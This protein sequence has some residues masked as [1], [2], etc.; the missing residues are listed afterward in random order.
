MRADNRIPWTPT[1]G[2]L[3]ADV[4]KKWDELEQSEHSRELAIHEELKR[5]ERLEQLAEIFQRKAKMRD[6]WL[7]DF[8]QLLLKVTFGY[9]FYTLIFYI[10]IYPRYFVKNISR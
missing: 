1:E 6:A 5:Q 10:G 4:Q 8:R 9:A 3:V 7:K 2:K